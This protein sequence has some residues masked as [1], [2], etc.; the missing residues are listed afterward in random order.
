MQIRPLARPVVRTDAHGI[1]KNSPSMR[2]V[3][4]R[5]HAVPVGHAQTFSLRPFR[6]SSFHPIQ[7]KLVVGP[8]NDPLEREADRVAEVAMS[9]RDNSTASVTPL[10]AVSRANIC[11]PGADGDTAHKMSQR[12]AVDETEGAPATV[13]EV[14]RS[15]GRAM[16]SRTRA[17][18]ETRFGRDFARVRVHTDG[19]AAE[20]ARSIHALAYTVGDHIAFGAGR[21]APESH[22]GSNLLAHELAHTVQ[23]SGGGGK[24]QRRRVPDAGELAATLPVGGTDLAAHEAGVVRLIR[25]AWDELSAPQKATVKT[26]AAGFGITGV[27]DADLFTHLAAGTREQILSFADAVR[28]A[29]PTATLGDPA[30]IDTGPRP[31]TADKAHINKLV[32]EADVKVFEPIHSGARNKDLRDIFGPGN[33]GRAWVKFEKAKAAMHRLRTAH[34]IVT[35]RSGSTKE[36]ET[37]GLSDSTQIALGPENI[38]NPT[39]TDSIA[40]IVHE[41]LHAGNT[42]V[43]DLGYIGSA[44]FPQMT[45]ADKL[46]NAADYEVIANRILTPGAADAFPGMKFIPAGTTVGGV[47]APPLTTRETA[48]R[49]ASETYRSAWTTGLNLHSLYVREYK[50]PAEWNTLDL[51]PEFAVGAGTHFADSLPFWSKV[52][53]MTIHQR[54]GIVPGAGKPAAPVTQVDIAQSE[55]VSHKLAKAMDAMTPSAL[56]DA[57]VAA[58]EAG[59]TAAQTA[60]IALGAHEEAKVLVSLIRKEKV[61]EITGPIERDERAVARMAAADQAA[62]FY[63]DVLTPKD[64]A[65]FAD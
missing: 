7:P 2:D 16:D 53:N 52:E 30:L 38:D 9:S 42:D 58:L 26:A 39:A 32:H 13:D 19:K 35:D 18:M 17:F 4:P 56:S 33:P 29:D 27:T 49:E 54:P 25:E 37:G 46:N 31:L 64:P 15:S 14:V 10:S 65:T 12:S 63:V 20:S 57:D 48:T 5:H 41:S 24:V 22:E 59:A 61:G 1:Q 21:Y 43:T 3:V 55:S 8:V 11:A 47:S 40:T 62:D 45:A 23:Q 50:N 60:Q 6:E 44:S 36:T 28:A 34:K 51:A